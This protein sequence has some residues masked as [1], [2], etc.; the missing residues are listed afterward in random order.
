MDNKKTYCLKEMKLTG[1]YN[2]QT[3]T[4][5]DGN[6]FY[7]NVLVLIQRNLYLLRQSFN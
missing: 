7:Q 5:I 6:F 3:I 4:L 1:N 2:I